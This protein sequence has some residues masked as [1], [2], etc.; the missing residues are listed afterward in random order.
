M[1]DDDGEKY[2]RMRA[3]MEKFASHYDAELKSIDRIKIEINNMTTHANEFS[4][5]RE[6]LKKRG[7]EEDKIRK[8]HKLFYEMMCQSGFSTSEEN[9]ENIFSAINKL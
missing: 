2:D 7:M 6:S 1:A 5:M 3:Y 8:N 4:S 9:V